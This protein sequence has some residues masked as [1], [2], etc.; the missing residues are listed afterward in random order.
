MAAEEETKESIQL[1]KSSEVS[2]Y[3]T[4]DSLPQSQEQ[5]Y[6]TALDS[7]FSYGRHALVK[8][9]HTTTVVD[10]CRVRVGERE[11]SCTHPLEHP[12]G[13]V[14]IGAGLYERIHEVVPRADKLV[15]FAVTVREGVAYSPPYY[16][17]RTCI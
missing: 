5:P 2:N 4:T 11:N 1:R 6:V 16:S 10:I 3:G 17:T 8:C 9:V 15:V 13:V 14:A 7:I 12:S